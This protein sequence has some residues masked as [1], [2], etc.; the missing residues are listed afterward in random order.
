MSF[1]PQVLD[2]LNQILCALKDGSNGSALDCAIVDCP[3]C[4]ASVGDSTSVTYTNSDNTTEISGGVGDVDGDGSNFDTKW[5]LGFGE[6]DSREVLTF[7]QECLDGGGR[8]RWDWTTTPVAEGE[9]SLT[10][11]QEFGADEFSITSESED[12]VSI[13]ILNNAMGGGGKIDMLTATCIGAPTTGEG[14]CLSTS[15]KCLQ[16]LMAQMLDEQ[17]RTNELLADLIEG[18][19][20][21][22]GVEC[23]EPGSGSVTVVAAPGVEVN[24]DPLHN[25]RIGDP[26][27]VGLFGSG[28]V[29][30]DF[31]VNP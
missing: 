5:N 9:P 1:S 25:I 2:L 30:Q 26:A 14:C 10:G 19:P 17:K 29:G 12:G 23:C 7:T 24:E 16:D 18:C 21:D 15:D 31:P 11:T 22:T 28:N 6:P 20:P 8:V 4:P 3:D 27:V 13:A